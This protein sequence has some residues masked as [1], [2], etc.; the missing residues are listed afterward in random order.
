GREPLLHALHLGRSSP[1]GFR[2][3]HRELAA[4]TTGRDGLGALAVAVRAAVAEH[5][6]ARDPVGFAAAVDSARQ[7]DGDT[8]TSAMLCGQLLGAAHGPTAIPRT[9][10]AHL[11]VG[12]IEQLVDEAI[13]EFGPRSAQPQRA[14]R[15][16]GSSS[17]DAPA[18]TAPRDA[19]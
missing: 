10:L 3:G 1:A 11:P 4:M 5:R 17:T 6:G 7:H 12:M 14:R 2:P 18:G 15:G 9:W 19:D 13:T 8:A 16:T